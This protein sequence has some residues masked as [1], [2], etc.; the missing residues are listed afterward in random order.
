MAHFYRSLAK[1]QI[2]LDYHMSQEDDDIQALSIQQLKKPMILIFCLWGAASTL[3]IAESVVF[4]WNQWYNW[5]YFHW[6]RI[7]LHVHTCISSWFDCRVFIFQN[8]LLD[9]CQQ[10]FTSNRM[11]FNV[12]KEFWCEWFEWIL[13]FN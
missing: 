6:T 11:C 10:N 12:N 8:L 5:G 3:L 9:N 13:R 7:I 4:K 1:F 2:S